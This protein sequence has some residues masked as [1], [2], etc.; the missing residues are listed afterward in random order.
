M[1]LPVDCC[2][3]KIEDGDRSD[4]DT[5]TITSSGSGSRADVTAAPLLD[6]ALATTDQ[7]VKNRLEFKGGSQTNVAVSQLLRKNAPLAGGLLG[8]TAILLVIKQLVQLQELS[9]FHRHSSVN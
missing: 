1:S 2:K 3:V 6:M 7:T 9:K 5:A 4:D 8:S